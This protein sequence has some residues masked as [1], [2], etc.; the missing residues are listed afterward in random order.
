MKTVLTVF[1][2]LRCTGQKIGSFVNFEPQNRPSSHAIGFVVI[3][4]FLDRVVMVSGS[5]MMKL[6][7]ERRID[8][9]QRV[10]VRGQ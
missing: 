6:E 2:D 5:F 3:F 4:Y 8:R 1:L 10:R 7:Q 9:V